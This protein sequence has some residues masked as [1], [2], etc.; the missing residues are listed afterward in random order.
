MHV[1]VFVFVC[2]AREG[3]SYEKILEQI[4]ESKEFR[5]N[6]TKKWNAEHSD[7]SNSH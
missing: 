7:L 4:L 1:F 5:I 2:E 6:I 3:I